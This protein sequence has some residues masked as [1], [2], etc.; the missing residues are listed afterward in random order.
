M[1]VFNLCNNTLNLLAVKA[2]NAYKSLEENSG[3]WKWFFIFVSLHGFKAVARGKGG[4][5]PPPRNQ[6]DCVENGV[7]SEGSIFSNNFQK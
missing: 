4:N 6:K 7:L 5:P 2:F 3:K 1:R